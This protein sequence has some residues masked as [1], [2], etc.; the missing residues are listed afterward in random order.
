MA[1]RSIARGTFLGMAMLL[2]ASPAARA[3]GRETVLHTFTNGSDGASPMAGLITDSAGN[4]YGTAAFGGNPPY[5]VV[6]KLSSDRKG[7][8]SYQVI[9]TLQNGADGVY[10]EGA[11]AMDG[12]G[13]LYGTTVYGGKYAE[14]TVFQLIPDRKGQWKL[15]KTYDF[16]GTYDGGKP[17]AGVILDSRGN[18]YGTTSLGNNDYGYGSVFALIPG[19]KGWTEKTVHLFTGGVDGSNPHGSL[20]VDRKGNLYGTAPFGGAYNE[21]IAFEMHPKGRQWKEIDLHDFTGGSDGQQPESNLIFDKSGNLYGTT[22]MGNTVFELSPA[23]GQGSWALATLYHFTGGADGNAPYSGLAFDKAG[24]LYGATALGG[25]QNQNCPNGECG[26]VYSLT[27]QQ[28]GQW[29]ENVLWSFTGGAD[30]A[31]P[32]ATLV[33][34]GSNKLYGTT[35]TGGQGYGVVFALKR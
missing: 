18:I 9:Y 32:Y 7:G 34:D 28:D 23:G 21:G 31:A 35:Y 11:L 4:L 17:T 33:F 3:A 27:P 8:W 16:V 10:P 5:G 12:Q 19:R 30:G 22:A 6:F 24:R 14:G 29:S 2:G 1:K 13:N 20:V 26:V 25:N 15:G